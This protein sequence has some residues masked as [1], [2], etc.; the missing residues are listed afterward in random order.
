MLA[1]LSKTSILG[2]S[3]HKLIQIMEI[4]QEPTRVMHLKGVPLKGWLLAFTTNIRLGLKGLQQQ[5]L[6]LIRNISK[7]WLQKFYDTGPRS[8]VDGPLKSLN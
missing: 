1:I 7:L 6:Q 4:R 2:Q 8:A 5:T 3:L